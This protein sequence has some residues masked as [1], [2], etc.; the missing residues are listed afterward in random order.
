MPFL[1]Q[2]NGITQKEGGLAVALLFSM[3]KESY[4]FLMTAFLPS[5]M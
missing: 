2:R 3:V 4:F 5:M 1:S